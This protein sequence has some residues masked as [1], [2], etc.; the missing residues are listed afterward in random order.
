MEADT[1]LR[2]AANI[3]LA[4]LSSGALQATSPM[5]DEYMGREEGNQKW[6]PR[7]APC[8]DT[9]IQINALAS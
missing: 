2:T 9:R 1:N 7:R 6:Y 5:R 3:D 8:V 4:P